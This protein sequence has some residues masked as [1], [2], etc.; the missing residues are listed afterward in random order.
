MSR[1]RLSSRVHVSGWYHLA[2]GVLRPIMMTCTVRD[3][4][5]ADNLRVGGS[6]EPG[7]VVAANHISWFDPIVL[8]HYLYDNGRLPRFLAKESVFKA[9]PLIGRLVT[10]AG[11]IPVY[12]GTADA[13]NA[14]RAAVE[15][16]EQGECVTIY[17][18]GTVTRESSLWPMAGKTGAVRIA[19]ASGAPLIPVAQWGAQDVMAPYTKEFRLLPRK[20]MHVWAG[21]P[22]DLDDLRG[23]PLDEAALDEATE[24][25]M[26]AITGMLEQIRAESA[27]AVRFVNDRPAGE[28]P[29]LTRRSRRKAQVR[30]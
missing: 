8:G 29:P 19:L 3:W 25:L 5:G 7:I 30:P 11:Q 1:V 23:H 15:K 16:A 26:A 12:R 2:L 13:K 18:E 21:P 9:K 24:R 14:L 4:R 17:P 20:T 27:P 28:R 22:I 6:L 10:G